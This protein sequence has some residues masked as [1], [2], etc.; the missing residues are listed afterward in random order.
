MNDQVIF[1][2]NSQLYVAIGAALSSI[3]EQLITFSELIHRLKHVKSAE[4]EELLVCSL[5]LKQKKST[6]LLRDV[7]RF[8]GLDV[9]S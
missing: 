9:V 6:S 5:Y 3:D 2:E 1:P 7:I 4:T 8:A